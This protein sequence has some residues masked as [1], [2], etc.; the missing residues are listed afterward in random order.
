MPDDENTK[1]E[2]NEQ[3]AEPDT[4]I[5]AQVSDAVDGLAGGGEDFE[6]APFM[7]VD[8]KYELAAALPEHGQ[9]PV[10]AGVIVKAGTTEVVDDW[11]IFRAQDRA[12]VPMLRQYFKI[13]SRLG[14]PQEHLEGIKLMINRVQAYQEHTKAKVPD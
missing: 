8:H 2:A 5:E 13:C 14:S 9:D 12:V 10:T 1:A 6:Q 4:D 11:I 3:P 7:P